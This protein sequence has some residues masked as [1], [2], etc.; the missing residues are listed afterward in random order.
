MTEI[1]K[2]QVEKILKETNLRVSAEAVEELLEV[3][4]EIALDIGSTSV[5]LAASAKR[6][7]VTISD[8]KLAVKQM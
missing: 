2:A 7:T 3:L 6:K 4:E 1:P 5:D 8:I